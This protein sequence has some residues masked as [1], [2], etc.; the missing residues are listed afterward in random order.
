MTAEM[1]HASQ[2]DQGWPDK[3]MLKVKFWTDEFVKLPREQ[4]QEDL[5]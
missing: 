5:V 4:S 1:A 3:Q 2:S